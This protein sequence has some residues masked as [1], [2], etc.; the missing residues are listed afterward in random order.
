MMHTSRMVGV[1]VVA[2]VAVVAGATC[3]GAATTTEKVERTATG[4][5]QTAKTGI[6]DSWV[7]A[8]T[9]LDLFADER[10]KGRQI[11]VETVK[12]AVTLRGKVD[13]NEA[14]AAAALH[15]AGGRRGQERKK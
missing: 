5:A 13:S 12:G 15:R 7:T 1:L 10:V 3:V 9:K 2:S 4:A 6:S 11:S 14:K 8:K